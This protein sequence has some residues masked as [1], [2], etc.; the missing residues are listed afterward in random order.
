MRRPLKTAFYVIFNA[1]N[2]THNLDIFAAYRKDN[3]VASFGKTPTTSG[4]YKQ[5][6]CR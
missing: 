4:I 2:A 6:R 5:C 3:S 1:K